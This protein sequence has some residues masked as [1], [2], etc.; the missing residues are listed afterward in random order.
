MAGR[1][2][3]IA[4]SA[5]AS[6]QGWY[7]WC[8]NRNTTEA[9]RVSDLAGNRYLDRHGNWRNDTVKDITGL[10]LRRRCEVKG[11]QYR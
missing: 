5:F 2:G 4:K 6:T 11:V 9:E 8:R 1:V 10:A 7:F 3:W